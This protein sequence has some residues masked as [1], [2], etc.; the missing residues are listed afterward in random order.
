[1]TTKAHPRR[2]TCAVRKYRPRRPPSTSPIRSFR[3]SPSSGATAAVATEKLSGAKWI[4]VCRCSASKP[5]EDYE[6]LVKEG[7]RPQNLPPLPRNAASCCSKLTAAVPHGGGKTPRTGQRRLPACSS[8]GSLRE[9]RLA[10]PT[11]R[12]SPGSKF[13]PDGRNHVPRW[14][15]ATA[16]DPRVITDGSTQDVTPPIAV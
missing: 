16:R 6:H 5:A 12:P 1:M 11:R 4:Q 10:A 9:C 2:S 7:P 13:F 15:A 14:R 8:D 3:S